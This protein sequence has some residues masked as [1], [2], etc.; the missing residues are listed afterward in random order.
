MRAKVW[1]R[2]ADF[3]GAAFYYLRVAQ[4]AAPGI[5][6]RYAKLPENPFPS[7]MAWSSPVWVAKK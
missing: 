7:E 2:D 3:S 1:W 4:E 6:A 5:V